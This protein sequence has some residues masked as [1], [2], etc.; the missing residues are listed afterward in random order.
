MKITWTSNQTCFH[1]QV[2]CNGTKIYIVKNDSAN[3]FIASKNEI[4]SI[5]EQKT[6]EII[7]RLYALIP[8]DGYNLTM[9]YRTVYYQFPSWYRSIDLTDDFTIISK[10]HTV[11]KTTLVKR[12]KFN[13]IA[14]EWFLKEPTI[15][16]QLE[17][18]VENAIG[19]LTI[20]SFAKTDIKKCQQDFN[21]FTDQAFKELKVN[22]IENLMVDLRDNTG[23]SDPYSAILLDYL[24]DKPFLYWNSIVVAEAI[25]KEIKGWALKLSYKMSVQKDSVWLW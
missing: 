24:S 18:K 19:F 25:A 2:Y 7:N 23:G 8:S 9:K 6:N 16:K 17:F 11:E 4:V 21:A 5:S 14:E 15:P 1:F 10:Q 3:K 22:N 20:H 12:A 13:D